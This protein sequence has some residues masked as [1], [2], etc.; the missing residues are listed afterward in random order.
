[1]INC[2]TSPTRMLLKS[3]QREQLEYIR[4]CKGKTATA[5]DFE[6]TR[7][8]ARKSNRINEYLVDNRVRVFTELCAVREQVRIAL[9]DSNVFIRCSSTIEANTLFRDGSRKK[10]TVI[11]TDSGRQQIRPAP[12]EELSEDST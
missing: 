4:Q 10:P 8:Q 9:H 2:W 6:D 11:S 1:M 7:S 12:T 5:M 3:Q